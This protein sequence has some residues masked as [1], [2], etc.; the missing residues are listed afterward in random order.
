MQTISE[1]MTC[2]V[3]SI[4]PQESLRR[5]AQLMDELNV[6]ALPVCEGDQLVGMVTDRDITVRGTSADIAP[7]D[8][9]VGD[10]MSTDVQWCFE[11]QSVDEVMKKMGHTQ[12]RRVPVLSHDERK[13]IGIVSLGDVATKADGGDRH[14]S[15]AMEQVSAPSEPDL[16]L[17]GKTVST[18]T[19]AGDLQPSGEAATR[20]IAETVTAD[21]DSGTPNRIRNTVS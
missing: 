11:D 19:R 4:S 20:R 12:I 6:G 21:V 5:A 10:V 18:G 15:R 8:A 17:V 13:L 9:T 2:N 14:V 1:V 3:Q 16:S 7:S